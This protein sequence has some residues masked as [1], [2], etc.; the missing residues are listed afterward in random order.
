MS[1]KKDPSPRDFGF[2]MLPYKALKSV[3]SN[4]CSYQWIPH[5]GI[6]YCLKSDRWLCRALLEQGRC[7]A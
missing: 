1:R 6:D 5:R 2:K 3:E 4:D 7:P